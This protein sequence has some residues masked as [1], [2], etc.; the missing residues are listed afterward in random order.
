[1]AGSLPCATGIAFAPDGRMFITLQGGVVRVW[2]GVLLPTPFI[3]LS[4]IVGGAYD[5][6]LL[7]IAVHPQF[8]QVP[9]VYLLFTHD[10]A[11]VPPDDAFGARVSRLVRVEADPAQGWNVA[12]PGSQVPQTTPGG[13]GHW[14]MLG[15]NSTLANIGNPLNG[16]DKTVA[17][18]MVGHSM[19]NPPVEDCL[20]SDELTHSIGTVTFASDGSMFISNGDG[21]DSSSID[22]R[23]FRGFN[24]D[25]LAGKILRIDPDTALGLPDNPYYVVGQPA[26]NRSKVWAYGLRNPFR[27]ALDPITNDPYVGDVGANTWEEINTGKA[28]SFG[29]P[30]YEGG[31]QSGNESGLTTSIPQPGFASNELTAPVCAALYAQGLG[32]VKPPT[33]AYIHPSGGGGAV[34][35]LGWY[36]GTTYP[37]VF[38]HALFFA[39]FNSAQVRYLTFDA[40]GVASPTHFAFGTSE[41]VSILQGPDT[42]LYAVLYN[43]TGS[44]V[45]RVRYT[46]GGNTPPTAVASATPSAGAAPLDVSFSAVASYDPDAQPLDY[47]WDFG[48]GTTSTLETPVHTYFAS[49]TFTATLTVT[50]Q[51]GSLASGSDSVVITVGSVPP[52][53]T[54]SQP[55]DGSTFAIGDVV[56]YAGSATSGVLSWELRTHH[57]DHQHYAPLLPGGPAG[58][59]PCWTT[60][61][62]CRSRSASP[63]PTR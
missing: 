16:R 26:R 2:D 27:M 37:S 11:G 34:V 53:A 12:L 38:Q 15:T 4:A 31:A 49:G 5:R 24:L 41:V 48:D 21:S 40:Q 6:G 33:F 57:N 17:S 30:C 20:P 56:T 44:H 35:G 61:T 62:A 25:S 7:G 51:T 18:C 22:P 59:S 29:W 36:S 47:H 55:L 8:P 42:N 45:V 13:P 58:P 28:V 63:P 10:P 19:A 32:A 52:V 46:A 39:D 60:P 1:M 14:I 3:D 23:A 9:Y 43:S 50:E 54:I